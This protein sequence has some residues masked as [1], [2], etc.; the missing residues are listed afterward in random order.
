MHPDRSDH[1][2]RFRHVRRLMLL[3]LLL[4][5][6]A[7][8]QSAVEVVLPAESRTQNGAPAL[9]RGIVAGKVTSLDL[10]APQPIASVT[11]ESD[12]IARIVL[13]DGVQAFVL[14][15][16]EIEFD[17]S[18][19]A[20]GAQPLPSGTRL[21]AS[22]RN[23]VQQAIDRWA[24]GWNI[25]VVV[26]GLF[27]MLTTLFIARSL[28]RGALG[29]V[30]LAIASGIALGV[31]YLGAP[32]LAPLVERHA[33]PLLDSTRVTPTP[34]EASTPNAPP[35]AQATPGTSS[36]DTIAK[37][38]SEALGTWGKQASDVLRNRPLPNPVYPAFFG[39]WIVTFV[40]LQAVLRPRR[41]AA[42]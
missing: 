2:A 33:Y 10:S 38:A 14:E 12:E 19:V 29:L 15:S 37:S 24:S 39:L 3:P 21:T 31:A 17:V 23:A 1:R 34:P 35:P 16:G 36:L 26:A 6:A 27:A 11:L 42:D 4:I 28:V 13:R 22:H 32:A 40:T 18:S 9:C 20:E 5:L 25:T 8:G 41:S 30:R 7:C